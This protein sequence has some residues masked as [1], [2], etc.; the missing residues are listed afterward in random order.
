MLIKKSDWKIFLE[1]CVLWVGHFCRLFPLSSKVW[2]PPRR[3]L[4]TPELA[5]SN[6]S[7]LV[8]AQENFDWAVAETI[9][10]DQVAPFQRERQYTVPAA[11]V[12]S[13]H[14]ARIFGD[15]GL[16]ITGDDALVEATA[17][18]WGR[19][20]KEHEIFRT[21]RL[22]PV[23]DH[24]NSIVAALATRSGDNYYHFLYEELPKYHLIQSFPESADLFYVHYHK[25]FQK[26][27]WGQLGLPES[28][29]I[30]AH[31]NEHFS[32]DCVL[33][34][35]LPSRNGEIPR[36]VI[37]F[38]QHR[39]RPPSN[40]HPSSLLYLD[41]S[42]CKGRKIVNHEEV[43]DLLK[44]F[45]FQKISPHSLSFESQQEIF[46]QAR[47]IVSPHGAALANLVFTQPGT[48]VIELFS[49]HFIHPCYW[50]IANLCQLKYQWIVGQGSEI[51]PTRIRAAN[52]EDMYIPLG[53]LKQ[54]ILE[55]L[56]T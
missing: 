28:S 17:P 44:N 5:D 46:A 3:I 33:A 41:R 29:L 4:M 45:G 54:W 13:L 49:P 8:F 24:K 39:F 12:F 32:A 38:L 26:E 22:P 47:L 21:F 16:V 6:E 48:C 31:A 50:K 53:Q 2:G 55:W 18:R 19:G 20:V 11:R 36:W 34:T 10:P 42:E 51:E 43:W 9:H 40:E 1:R 52:Q 15:M 23:R 14:S 25:S 7:Q 37:E 56:K 27:A 30:P 35:T